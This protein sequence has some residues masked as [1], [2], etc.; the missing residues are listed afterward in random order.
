MAYLSIL[1]GAVSEGASNSILGLKEHRL[2][3]LDW[4]E[5]MGLSQIAQSDK[6]RRASTNDGNAHLEKM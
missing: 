5:L 1:V 2:D 6:P 4:Q 3:R